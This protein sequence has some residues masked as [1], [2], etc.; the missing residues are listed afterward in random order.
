MASKFFNYG[1]ARNYVLTSYRQ[2]VR[3]KVNSGFKIAGL[4][5][6]L[7][8][9]LVVALYLSFQFS[10]DRYHEGYEQIYRINTQRTENGN[11]EQY[12]IAPLALGPM[13][14][15]GFP[16]LEAVARF[17]TS[18]ASQLIYKDKVVNAGV[19]AVDST[20]FD[21]FS[22]D[23]IS[24]ARDPLTRPGSIV[25]TEK[26]AKKIFA[27]EDPLAKTLGLNN[28]ETLYEVTAV[29]QDLPNNSH[30]HSEAF[31]LLNRAQDFNA[32]HI[33]SPPEFVDNSAVTFVKFRK[34]VALEQFEAR[35]DKVLDQYVP[36]R[37]R[38][39]LGFKIFV[40]PLKDIYL[41]PPLKYEFTRKG[42][43]VY[44]YI[45][46]VLGFFLLV[47]SCINYANLSLATFMHR[48]REM[49]IR[50]VL[51]GRKSQIVVQIVLDTLIFC[52]VALASSLF[53]LY[54]LFPQVTQYVEPHLTLSM[55]T[56]PSFIAI[57]ASLLLLMIFISSA[58]PAFRLATNSVTHDLK[59]LYA[60][61][62]KLRFNNVLLLA[63]F[64]ISIICIG[65]TLTVGKQV[66]FIH[67]KDLGIDRNN[68]LVLTMA[69]GFTTSKMLALKASLKSIPG[70]TNVSNSSFRMGGGYWKDW[71]TIE[72]DGEHR[73][74]ELYEVFSDDD[75]F[76]TLGVKVLEGRVFDAAHK[77]DSGAAFVINETAARQ[78]GLSDPVGTKILTHPEEP[79][80]WEGTIV[81][82]VNDVNISTLHQKVQPLV[83]RLP[84]QDQFP[85]Y[86]VY[87]RFEHG[88]ESVIRSIKEKYSELQQ[89]YPLEVQLVD[90]FYNARYERENRAYAT[91]R[92]GTTV[93]L[94]I[95]SLGIFSLSIY[96]SVRKMK[97]FG[98]RKVLGATAAHITYMH[99]L[100]FIRVAVVA[101][102]IAT[103]VVIFLM[104][105]WLTSF[106]YK[107]TQ[108]PGSVAV[109]AS[110]TLILIVMSAGY[111]AIRAGRMNPIEVIKK[112]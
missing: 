104:N 80:R 41:A 6:A 109:M 7:F 110:I 40:Q 25:L 17:E 16:E 49:G 91:L 37:Q 61:G 11:L 99:I 111:A 53:L 112:G 64:V 21:I 106:A 4:T 98:I 59:G 26:L 9:L 12:G 84:W 77:A 32:Q 2:V 45:F 43:M 55:M 79:G 93:I 85:E 19:F 94:L 30:I 89:G 105:E 51:G 87:V 48:S 101:L 90:E 83:M 46:S 86:F 66:D 60:Q 52:I 58:V 57:I 20:W 14:S 54:L 68:L 31:V 39:E 75:L 56:T 70:V 100:H 63:Q 3:D 10:F 88:L 65:A 22:H 8:S 62:G 97:E 92:F 107:A 74:Y 5:L 27:D 38:E 23:F 34:G 13:L 78:L 24:G 50:K 42:S 72:V 108:A 76:E 69:E 82:V 1:I 81:G 44:L 47:I 102:L 33:I 67:H 36:R 96:L 73:T 29:I 95:S 15:E 71:Y 103:P 18:N 35:L 28:N